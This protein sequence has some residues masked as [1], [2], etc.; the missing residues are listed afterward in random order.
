[1]YGTS[2]GKVGYEAGVGQGG[3]C[4]WGC[5][6]MLQPVLHGEAVIGVPVPSH[7]WIHHQCLQPHARSWG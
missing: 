5:V 4:D 7:H 1:M 2:D 6:V 3:P